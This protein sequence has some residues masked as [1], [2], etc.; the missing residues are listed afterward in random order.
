MRIA[1]VSSRFNRKVCDGLLDG[2]KRALRELKIRNA[3]V[4]RVPGSFEIPVVAKKLVATRKYDAVV[5]IG[6]IIKGET[7]HDE[8]LAHA[9]TQMLSWISFIYGVPVTFGI[10]TAMSDEQALARAGRDREN[11]GYQAARAAVEMVRTLKR[12]R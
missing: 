11:R 4:V 1:I 12:I 8:Y 6:A 3:T 5:A 2:A 10:I 9:V 7:R